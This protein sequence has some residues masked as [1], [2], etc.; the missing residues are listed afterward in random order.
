MTKT[1][2]D[3]DRARALEFEPLTVDVER[4][5]LRF[6]AETIAETNPIYL[7]VAAAQA[8]G[9]RDV[10]V[11]P[12]F[13]FS[14]ALEAPKPFGYLDALG[15]DLRH[16]LHGEQSFV[17][18]ALAYA[19]DR[20]VLQDRITDVYA[21]RG[22]SLE[23]VVKQTDVSRKDEPIAELTTVIVVRHPAAGEQA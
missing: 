2:I 15:V 9:H 17:Y 18:H 11:P 6:F 10:P 23:F 14:L 16:V 22:G 5:R 3:A 7:D 20:L 1:A 12:T 21:K 8:A 4:G 13:Y 19:G